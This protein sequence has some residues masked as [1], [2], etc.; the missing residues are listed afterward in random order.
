MKSTLAISIVGPMS[1]FNC[2]LYSNL[3]LFFNFDHMGQSIQ[4]Q[5][6]CNLW[7]TALKKFEVIRSFLS[8]SI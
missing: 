8:I 2:D 3:I 6:K 1:R 5:I 4:E 7:K